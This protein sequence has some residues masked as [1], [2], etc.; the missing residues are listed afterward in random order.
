MT[1]VLDVL[2]FIY[3][4]FFI[5]FKIGSL[6]RKSYFENLPESLCHSVSDF[7]PSSMSSLQLDSASIKNRPVAALQ[8]QCD[9]VEFRDEMLC[10][11]TLKPNVSCP[12]SCLKVNYDRM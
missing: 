1:D 4:L 6:H 11:H 3:F 9:M 5:F 7:L 10:R 2:R 12:K 8:P